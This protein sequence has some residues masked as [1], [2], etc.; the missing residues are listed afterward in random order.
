M[1]ENVLIEM[2]KCIHYLIREHD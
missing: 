2:Q 1:T